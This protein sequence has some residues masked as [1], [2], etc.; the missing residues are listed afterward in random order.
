M[1]V[2]QVGPTLAGYIIV[3]SEQ[4]EKIAASM[5]RPE[6]FAGGPVRSETIM[7]AGLDVVRGCCKTRIFCLGSVRVQSA[8]DHHP[9]HLY[10]NSR[11]NLQLNVI[12]SERLLGSY[13]CDVWVFV[14]IPDSQSVNGWWI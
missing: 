3:L 13:I 2:N 8:S 6:L 7:G 14:V 9:H 12:P 10:V 1:L 4:S 5:I 11:C